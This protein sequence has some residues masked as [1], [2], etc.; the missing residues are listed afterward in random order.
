MD[1]SDL[2]VWMIEAFYVDGPDMQEY[3]L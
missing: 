2:G 3:A 1:D